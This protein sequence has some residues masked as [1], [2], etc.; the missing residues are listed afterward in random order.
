MKVGKLFYLLLF[1]IS[2]SFSESLRFSP[3]FY[4]FGLLTLDTTASY[5]FEVKN[6]SFYEVHICSVKLQ[7]GDPLPVFSLGENLCNEKT[8]LPD[9]SCSIQV[10]FRPREKKVYSGRLVISYD[11]DM[12]GL[13]CNTLKEGFIELE[14]SG[15]SLRV[16]RVQPEP[17][18][19]GSYFSFPETPYGEVSRMTFRLCNAGGEN[20]IFPERA[21]TLDN[22]EVA[23]F[24]ISYNTCNNAV[25]VYAPNNELCN[26]NFCEFEIIF[27]PKSDVS[28]RERV[29]AIVHIND[30]NGGP[31]SSPSGY[32]L[33]L[34]ASTSLPAGEFLN[35]PVGGEAHRSFD[36]DFVCPDNGNDVPAE[37]I[38]IGSINVTLTGLYFELG[39]V[40]CPTTCQEGLNVICSV[41]V[42]FKPEA[43][44]IYEG[45]V[46]I[47][48]PDGTVISRRIIGISGSFTDNY[49]Q[50]FP[51]ELVYGQ[52][53]PLNLYER[54]VEVRNV[55]GGQI[56]FDV[57]VS[58]AG[59]GISKISCNC[60]DKYIYNG[61]LCVP[62]ERD[63]PITGRPYIVKPGESC[64]IYVYFFMPFGLPFTEYSGEL[65]VSTPIDNYRIPLRAFSETSG[66]TP[67]PISPP[68]IDLGS[69]SG[70]C[71][72]AN[73]K[74][75]T[76]VFL[77]AYLMKYLLKF[78]V[79]III[80][81][82]WWE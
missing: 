52:V 19:S 63:A 67:V 53:Y 75:I 65:I 4:N 73:Y 8:L 50:T 39:N 55:T 80:W 36:I 74:G 29:S 60:N 10:F 5:T 46:N 28:F 31:N 1:F 62:S 59:F 45:Q 32:S 30:L 76:L 7:I 2:F 44:G 69:G 6:I 41:S 38:T 37:T 16:V 57:Y 54:A 51:K 82:R 70:G 34:T 66:E 14:G 27:D 81:K 64:I 15:T 72:S 68:S 23:M 79:K 3:T 61:K 24:G 9:E 26:R 20:V 49:L 43:A 25:L 33:F 22:Q 42:I 13:V 47:V 18:I 56:P 11:D 58:G 12:D 35:A 71:S 77:I 17:V 48:F 40:N 21:I 78:C